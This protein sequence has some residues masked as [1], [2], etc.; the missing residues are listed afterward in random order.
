MVVAASIVRHGGPGWV[1]LLLLVTFWNTLRF[2]V[3]IPVSAVRLL[4]IRHQ[5]KILIRDWQRTQPADTPAAAT[6]SPETAAPASP[7]P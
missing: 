4:R 3:L 2:A 7:R 6:A 1:N 5:E